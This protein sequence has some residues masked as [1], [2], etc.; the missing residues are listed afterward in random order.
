MHTAPPTEQATV[1]TPPAYTTFK[2]HAAHIQPLTHAPPPTEAHETSAVAP[3][4]HLITAAQHT[5]P[6]NGFALVGDKLGGDDAATKAA[7]AATVRT[8]LV[9][10]ATHA[11]PTA[12][13]TNAPTDAPVTRVHHATPHQQ[14]QP[15]DADALKHV[16]PHKLP[17]THPHDNNAAATHALPPVSAASGVTRPPQT[18]ADFNNL[19]IAAHTAPP[20]P[21]A[22]N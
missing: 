15:V 8:Q 9:A 10:V 13:P 16:A 14:Q 12:A 17:S 21:G 11:A 7:T 1:A 3:T 6:K 2:P 22:T 19:K 20:L 4:P 5:R 18:S